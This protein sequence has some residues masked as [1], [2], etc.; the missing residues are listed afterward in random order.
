MIKKKINPTSPWWLGGLSF[1]SATFS[2]PLS[3]GEGF[4]PSPYPA[5]KTPPLPVSP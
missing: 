1:F 3:L 5:L 2:F 4:Y